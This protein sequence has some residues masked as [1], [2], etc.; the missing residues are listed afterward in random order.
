MRCTTVSSGLDHVADELQGRALLNVTTSG[1]KRYA[2]L[3]LD[4]WKSEA[5]DIV[6]FP[7]TGDRLDWVLVSRDLRI[8]SHRVLDDE[9]SDHRVIIVEVELIE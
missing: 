7:R 8:R 2:E 9:V 4:T 5:E 6:T 3:Q 1:K